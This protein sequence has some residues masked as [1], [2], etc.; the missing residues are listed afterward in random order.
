V[1]QITDIH[2]DK[3]YLAGSLVRSACHQPEKRD[4]GSDQNPQ[5]RKYN[6]T[7]PHDDEPVFHIAFPIDIVQT[8]EI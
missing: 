1:S 2:P 3:W 5:N 4:N 7:D 6:P 8:D